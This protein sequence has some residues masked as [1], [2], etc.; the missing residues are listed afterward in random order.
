MTLPAQG[1]GYLVSA[2]K[3]VRNAYSVSQLF[4]FIAEDA[5]AG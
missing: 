5:P 3:P 2:Q 1:A 4:P